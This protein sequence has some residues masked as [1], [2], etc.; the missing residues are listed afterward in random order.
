MLGVGV[1]G[2]GRRFVES[3]SA[4]S[5]PRGWIVPSFYTKPRCLYCFSAS[6]HRALSPYSQNFFSQTKT[7]CAIPRF[8]STILTDTFLFYF[9]AGSDEREGQN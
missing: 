4:L 8:S 7:T 5:T 3:Q 2:E 9:N 1:E 6:K